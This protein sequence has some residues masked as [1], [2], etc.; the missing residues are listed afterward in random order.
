MASSVKKIQEWFP[1]MHR[2]DV[3]DL[4]EA[5]LCIDEV[6]DHSSA[7]GWRK[8]RDVLNGEGTEFIE[9]G[10]NSR[11]PWIKYVNMGDPYNLTV[12]QTGSRHACFLGCWG[13]IVER[14]SYD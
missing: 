5:M 4:R 13:D 12:I 7:W 10:H 3:D 9:E 1:R 2:A 6:G 11:S 14:G 8:A